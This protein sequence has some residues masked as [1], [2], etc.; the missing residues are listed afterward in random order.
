MRPKNLK[1]PFRWEE[2]APLFAD[3]VLYVPRY[4]FSHEA[5]AD[6]GFTKALEE[7]S[8]VAIEYCSGNGTWIAEK[9]A[10]KPETLWIAVEKRFDRVQKIW[11][12]KKNH[13][14][15]NL[16]IVCGAAEAFTKHYLK[17]GCINE[18][19]VNFPDPWPKEKHAK[20]RLFQ[21]PFIEEM[22][23]VAK[24]DARVLL[25]TDDV[26]YSEQMLQE[27]TGEGLFAPALS[28]PH[29]STEWEGY[30][31]SFFEVLWREKGRT[32]RYLPFVQLSQ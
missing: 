30:G 9:A 16:L 13:G 7:F 2:R 25:V 14:L 21:R 19:Y 28:A 3:G 4:Y 10:E 29:Y 31:T 1:F 18:I 24:E 12:K 23:R 6:E 20:N 8:S 15:E 17:D 11:A 22:K 32:I 5:F 27:M 26:E